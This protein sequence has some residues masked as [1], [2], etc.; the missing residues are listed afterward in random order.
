MSL[1]SNWTGRNELGPKF[2]NTSTTR[3]QIQ[4]QQAAIQFEKQ[5]IN[6]Q[7][8]GRREANVSFKLGK[9][10]K[11]N[12]AQSR[13]SISPGIVDVSCLLFWLVVLL[14][15]L[16]FQVAGKLGCMS[17]AGSSF[18]IEGLNGW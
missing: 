1:N 10:N 16:W 4:M 11:Q 9:R 5:S 6:S 18:N 7:E 17:P 2:T 14:A 15:L 3:L 13:N 12:K 8:S